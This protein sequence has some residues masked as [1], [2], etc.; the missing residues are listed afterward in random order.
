MKYHIQGNFYQNLFC[1][2]KR[3]CIFQTNAR[4]RK[5]CATINCHVVIVQMCINFL[6]I[7][8]A[9]TKAKSKSKFVTI[10]LSV[11]LNGTNMKFLYVSESIIHENLQLLNNV[12]HVHYVCRSFQ[13]ALD[14]FL[15][16]LELIKMKGNLIK[17]SR[18]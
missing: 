14:F 4:L 6:E 11:F 12:F 2:K 7:P 5:L 18:A 9:L 17:E 15:H 10:Y 1:R 16:C 13:K 8:R 3:N